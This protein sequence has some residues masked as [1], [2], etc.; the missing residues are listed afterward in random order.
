MSKYTYIICGKLYN[1]IDAEFKEGYKILV[2][3]NKIEAVGREIP[4]PE[5]AE[6]VD[7]S[8]ATVTPGMIDAHMHMDYIDWHTIREEVYTTSEEAKTIAIIR[9]AQ[10]TLSRGFTTVRHPGG[11]TSNGFG[12]LDVK[13]AIEKGYITGSRIVAAPRFL[14]AAGSHGD[15][16]QGFARNPE[17]SNI[18]QNLRLSLGAGKDF[19]VNAV[20]EEIKYG[21]DF[22]KI[23]AT[24]GFFTPYDNPSQQQMNDEELKAIME[25]GRAHV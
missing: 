19:F 4:Q 1:G 23:M 3:D 7:L 22:I 10:K 11:I 25:I 13:R 16:S 8:D 5:T 14:C 24:G 12:V 21:A 15:L 9:T 6:V 18:V 2:K 20:R 17:L